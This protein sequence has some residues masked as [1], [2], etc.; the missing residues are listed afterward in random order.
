MIILPYLSVTVTMSARQPL[1]TS[2]PTRSKADPSTI[3]ARAKA[4]G[5]VQNDHA[6]A[7]KET[8]VKTASEGNL[9]QQQ[10]ILKTYVIWQW[11]K[12]GK[13]WIV[14][15]CERSV[16]AKGS[17]LPEL[18]E[19]K[20]FWRFF[21]NQSKGLLGE[22]PT[23]VSLR[24]SAKRLKAGLKRLTGAE[25][26]DD[27]TA[28]IN[29]WLRWVIPYEP[30]SR[31]A[32]I[33]R[34]K[35]LFKREDLDRNLRSL[36]SRA[37][38]NIPHERIRYNVHFILLDF[39]TSGG[40]KGHFFKGGRRYEHYK[41]VLRRT[42]E[43]PTFSYAV[44]QRGVK[45]N[46]DAEHKGYGYT[47]QEH[48]ILRYN[49]PWLLIQFAIADRALDADHLLRVLNGNGDG[50]INWI[51]NSE[52]LPV[53]PGVDRQGNLTK[54][55]M[56]SD[57]FDAN[58]KMLFAAE[59][60]S[61]RASIHQI[62]REVGKMIDKYY[63]ETQRSQHLVQSDPTVFGQ[64]YVA[65]ISSCDGFVA[66]LGEKPNHDAADYFQGMGQ[67]W[68]PGMPVKLPASLRQ[69]VRLSSELVDIAEK[70]KCCTGDELALL[71]R[72][73][74]NTTVRLERAALLSYREDC[75]KRLQQ[76][77]LLHGQAPTQDE[78]DPL[79]D[80]LPERGRIAD[81]M[82]S[83][84]LFDRR[85]LGQLSDDMQVVLRESGAV[86][87]RPNESPVCGR[88]SNCNTDI[89]GLPKRERCDHI[90]RCRRQDVAKT[91]DVLPYSLRFCYFCFEFYTESEWERDCQRHISL[92]FKRCGVF[93]H[94]S[95]L[96]RPAF[97]LVCK[98]SAAL[99]ASQRLQYW[100][101]DCDAIAHIENA[102]GWT[103]YCAECDFSSQD[104]QSGLY[105]LADHHG[106]R[107]ST[108]PGTMETS[109][110]DEETTGIIQTIKD[111]PS[112]AVITK[113][114]LLLKQSETEVELH[115]MALAKYD[116]VSEPPP[117]R[118]R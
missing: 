58:F 110:K 33:E 53:C 59:Y 78:P 48:S 105:H 97:C 30:E 60:K 100:R 5:Y 64:S 70:M 46:R 50:T 29:H 79:R 37:D 3:I 35:Y 9:Q 13:Q 23:P 15:E 112:S 116:P 12:S 77:K 10:Y 98:Q 25:L 109:P 22:G 16:L 21:I 45:G 102:H 43:G 117:A 104:Q 36:Y 39:C 11:S 103:W 66:F 90:H 18:H 40:R 27:A 87:Y 92:R 68:Q 76:E 19:L 17:E 8:G 1:P 81:A 38:L 7:D 118:D 80:V 75:F 84:Q 89:E 107:V 54:K 2:G 61:A 73:Q 108:S 51:P 26:S 6:E 91:L 111:E 20:D 24:T 99:S 86:F 14:E 69:E 63:T 115:S 113:P 56:T 82:Q 65:R 57:V 83:D 88:C 49:A 42:A 72:D 93:T 47:R 41:L 52:T 96:V 44:D 28:E 74:R 85:S 94:R 4:N 95:T 31:V 34:P 32:P 71:K 114:P 106:Y 55:P 101:R 67:F 62:R